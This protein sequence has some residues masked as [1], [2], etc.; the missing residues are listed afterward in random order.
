MNRGPHNP[1][2]AHELQDHNRTS[3][4][5]GDKYR[6]LHAQNSHYF[7]PIKWDSSGGTQV[8]FSVLI[9]MTIIATVLTEL[10]AVTRGQ[11]A[12]DGTA[13]PKRELIGF[14][15]ES[16]QAL[17]LLSRDSS[18][19]LQ[20]LADEAF[21]DLLAKHRRPR[22]LKDALKQSATACATRSKSA[23]RAEEHDIFASLAEC[24]TA[25][26][27]SRATLMNRPGANDFLL[28]WQHSRDSCNAASTGLAMGGA[29][30]PRSA[31][32][33]LSVDS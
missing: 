25:L 17:D 14:D 4:H 27:S 10:L 1:S 32:L 21:A 15:P 16:W 23:P 2:L 12:E 33:P 7:P 3:D 20:E 30:Q 24:G 8:G 11:G 26:G 5:V 28:S 9:A 13:T 22:T 18:K 29:T 6:V 19:D 31:L